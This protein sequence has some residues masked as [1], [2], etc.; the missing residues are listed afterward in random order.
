MAGR[1]QPDGRITQRK[2]WVS[3]EEITYQYD[4]L[5]RLISAQTTGPEL[6]QSFGYDGF[7]NLLSQTSSLDQQERGLPVANLGAM[8]F[9]GAGGRS[10]RQGRAAADPPGPH[11][12]TQI[13]AAATNGPQFRVY[14]YDANG[15]MTD[16]DGLVCTWDYKDRVVAVEDYTLRAEYTY[17]YTDRRITK[18]VIPKASGPLPSKHAAPK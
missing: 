7:G 3:G 2:D 10:G 5:N 4:S 18:R 14:P 8:Q 1:W 13:T 17:D 6:G 11:A 15:N 12:L 16:L 9:G